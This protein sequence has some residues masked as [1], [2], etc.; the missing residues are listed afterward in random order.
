MN[1][2]QRSQ[3]CL[4]FSS[5]IQLKF[6]HISL[7]KFLHYIIA[8]WYGNK[9][10]SVK[11]ATDSSIIYQKQSRSCL[12]LSALL[13]PHMQS[14]RKKTLTALLILYINAFINYFLS[15][16]SNLIGFFDVKQIL[17]VYMQLI[18]YFCLCDQKEKRH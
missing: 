5:Y 15:N 7:L 3:L 12:A 14:G 18:F 6:V 1:V 16:Q 9:F 13:T 4:I 2:L 10:K 17:S 11:I 8:V